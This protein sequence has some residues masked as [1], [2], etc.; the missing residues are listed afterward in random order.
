M[1]ERR[2]EAGQK[3]SL[4][5]ADRPGASPAS[6]RERV[7]LLECRLAELRAQLEAARGEADQARTRLAESAAREADHA[8]RYAAV[9]QEIAG[10]R[11]DVA[12]MHRRLERSE[13]LRAVLINRLGD[14]YFTSK[15][16]NES[17]RAAVF[18]RKLG[19]TQRGGRPIL[20][21]RF[22]AA[23]LGGHAVDMLLRGTMNACT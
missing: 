1:G 19:H 12:A 5:N 9:H 13:A 15:R 4:H 21:D 8:R 10:A 7:I 6:D 16:R 22:H 20:F 3:R 18:T 23:Q 14:T 2:E 17:A 11:A